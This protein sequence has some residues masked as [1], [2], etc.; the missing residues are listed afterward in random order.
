MTTAT[1]HPGWLGSFAVVPVI[2]VA[3]I[4]GVV[5]SGWNRM[6]DVVAVHWGAGG[7]PDGGLAKGVAFLLPLGLFLAVWGFAVVT[8]RQPSRTLPGMA[9]VVGFV[10]G[11]M[12][13]VSW[14]VVDRNLDAESWESAGDV[15]P[16][17]ILLPVLA[18]AATAALSAWMALRVPMPSRPEPGSTP[19]ADLPSGRVAWIGTATSRSIWIAVVLLLGLAL[20]TPSIVSILFLVLAVLIAQFGRVM[21]TI[22]DGEVRW[23]AGALQFPRGSY[24]MSEIAQATVLDINPLDYGGWGYRKF[25]G[26]TAIVVRRGEGISIDLLDGK[27]RVVATDGAYEAAGIINALVRRNRATSA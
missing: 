18:A 3:M 1:R 16:M 5:A 12:A 20:F 4:V 24:P 23:A 2:A 15:S 9:A 21:V 27:E 22:T 6:P 7:A 26:G 25:P 11:I 10:A 8:S 17:M 14:I 13:T 19:V